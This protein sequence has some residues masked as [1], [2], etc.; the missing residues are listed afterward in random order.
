MSCKK[1]TPSESNVFQMLYGN[2]KQKTDENENLEETSVMGPEK[3][4]RKPNAE[5]MVP[6]KF[7]LTED[8]VRALDRRRYLDKSLD[9]SGHVRAALEIY[10]A[11]DLDAIRNGRI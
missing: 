3:R 1:F 7:S 11:E 9:I 6:R 2:E 5:R 10:L 4:G 8:L